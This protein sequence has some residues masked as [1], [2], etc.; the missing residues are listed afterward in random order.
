MQKT[1]CGSLRNW[2]SGKAG[3]DFFPTRLVSVTSTIYSFR[4]H[5]LHRVGTTAC[6]LY[7]LP[8]MP[9]GIVVVIPFF[10]SRIPQIQTQ[11]SISKHSTPRP[12]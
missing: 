9:Y 4:I 8:K 6:P 2:E 12:T 10:A 7:C 1:D 11:I 5:T 3:Q